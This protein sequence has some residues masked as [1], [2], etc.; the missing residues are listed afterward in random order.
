MEELYPKLSDSLKKTV[1]IIE[2]DNQLRIELRVKSKD[3]LPGDLGSPTEV[4][5]MIRIFGGV[6][7]D[8]IMEVITDEKANIITI[9]LRKRQDFEIIKNAM[10]TIW[11][12]TAKLLE[13]AISTEPGRS[14][15]FKA[16]G[17]FDESY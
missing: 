7:E 10:R 2:I 14:D 9:K 16:L 4:K 17:D 3:L 1:E 5:E 13:R 6:S 8:I 15:V 11:E 12:R